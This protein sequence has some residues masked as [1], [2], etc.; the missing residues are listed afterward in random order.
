MAHRIRILLGKSTPYA[1]DIHP[2]RSVP[3]AMGADDLCRFWEWNDVKPLLFEVILWGSF[4]HWISSLMEFLEFLSSLRNMNSFSWGIKNHFMFSL[5]FQNWGNCR[6]RKYLHC[7][8]L[9]LGLGSCPRVKSFFCQQ[10]LRDLACIV[11]K[12]WNIM[13]ITIGK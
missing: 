6:W 10:I 2:S 3:I 11:L 4:E 9:L 8:S 5:P 7:L 12:G 1:V 13:C